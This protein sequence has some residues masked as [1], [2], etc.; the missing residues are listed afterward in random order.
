[1]IEQRNLAAGS[2]SEIM[3]YYFGK[4]ETEYLSVEETLKLLLDNFHNPYVIVFTGIEKEAVYRIIR[5][6]GLHPVLASECDGFWFNNKENFL[7]LGEYLFMSFND[8]NYYTDS[9]EAPNSI[10]ILKFV[11][12]LLIFSESPVYCIKKLF[13]AQ[14]YKK[15]LQKDQD[16]TLLS[17]E[18][19]DALEILLETKKDY[20]LN[21]LECVLY[22]LLN[23]LFN[24]LERFV[25]SFDKVSKTFM[26][27]CNK[28]E[29]VNKLDFIMTLSGHKKKFVFISD[30]ITPKLRVL[31]K[32][33]R[34]KYHPANH[35]A[36]KAHSL[37][38]DEL[39][40]FLKSFYS[41][42]KVFQQRLL[43][44]KN[45]LETSENIFSVQ[46]D[47]AMHDYSLK[48]NQISSYFTAVT[49][50]FSPLVLMS[51]FLGMNV[52]VPAQYDLSYDAFDYMI[53]VSIG[54]ILFMFAVYK[55][56]NWI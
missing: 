52:Q 6:L 33:I 34:S 49:T 19:H 27:T 28:I 40:Y 41:K 16:S 24:R 8:A 30:L 55:Y 9:F 18:N 44:S 11:N 51:A 48:L 42:T 46:T 14:V 20:K 29:Q 15:F 25:S 35:Y 50:T 47:Q 26:D 56:L 7:N 23:E 31:R 2:S 1:M 38:S 21:M 37:I 17:Q 10:K 5:V 53:G 45:M 13:K 54:F 36:L 3:A 22:R 32:L 12:K 43:M 4:K 39:K